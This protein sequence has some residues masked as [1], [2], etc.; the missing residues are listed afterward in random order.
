MLVCDRHLYTHTHTTHTHSDRYKY[1]HTG[2]QISQEMTGFAETVGEEMRA[3]LLYLQMEEHSRSTN[4][5]TMVLY[6]YRL[7][8]SLLFRHFLSVLFYTFSLPS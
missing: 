2:Y 4:M 1:K 7:H 8:S 3:F 6:I 5:L